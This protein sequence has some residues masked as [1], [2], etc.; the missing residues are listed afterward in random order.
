V[1]EGK[2]G[3]AES[4]LWEESRARGDKTYPTVAPRRTQTLDKKT[5]GTQTQHEGSDAKL[6]ARMVKVKRW[7]KAVAPVT[8]K[9]TSGGGGGG[10]GE[11]EA[12]PA[13]S[14]VGSLLGRIG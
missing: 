6:E 8:K 14:W 5:A 2:G 12:K 13:S 10:T 1:G 4:T 11:G 3:T 9:R 7:W